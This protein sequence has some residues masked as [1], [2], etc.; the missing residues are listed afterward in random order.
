M[1]AGD[2]YINLSSY[3]YI[4]RPDMSA[5]FNFVVKPTYMNSFKSLYACN[6]NTKDATSNPAQLIYGIKDLLPE[7][8]DFQASPIINIDG[9][10]DPSMIS[11]MTQSNATDLKFTWSE[12]GDDI[13][14]RMLW[15]DTDLIENKYHKANFIVPNTKKS[16]GKY[17]VS[18]AKFIADDGTAMTGT[19]TTD[20]EGVCGWGRHT[21][22]SEDQYAVG[23][24]DLGSASEFTF[25]CHVKP[26]GGTSFTTNDR[27]IFAASGNGY[28][29]T[30]GTFHVAALTNNKIKVRMNSGSAVLTSTTSYSYDNKQPL[31]IVVTYNKNLASNNFKLYINGKLEDTDDYTTNFAGS[32][33]QRVHIGVSASM[34]SFIGYLEEFTFHSKA[35]Y[36]PQ[37][38]KQFILK[39]SELPDMSSNESNKYQSRLFLFDYH[40]VRGTNPTEVCKSNTT[41]WK[42]TGVT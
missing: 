1:V 38:N 10:T 4:A 17:Y 6:V 31:A 36:I 14:Y 37:N 21:P 5:P 40:N 18:A 15:V 11:N 26:S 28:G 12:S 23:P 7:V 9:I 33:D 42:V 19:Y 3:V 24:L 16:N 13:N 25:T 2:N 41:S 8:E 39:T 22:G 32:T 35:A 34:H 27:C 29:G 30:Y 20:I